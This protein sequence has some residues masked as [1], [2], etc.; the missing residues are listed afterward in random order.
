[1]PCTRTGSAERIPT[2]CQPRTTARLNCLLFA[3]LAESSYHSVGCPSLAGQ[4]SECNHESLGPDGGRSATHRRAVHCPHAAHHPPP[5]LRACRATASPPRGPLSRP[6]GA[7][8]LFH[9]AG[10]RA[11][12]A[13]APAR[14]PA[15]PVPGPLHRPVRDAALVVAAAGRSPAADDHRTPRAPRLAPAA[16]SHTTSPHPL[17]AAARAAPLAAPSAPAVRRRSC[18]GGTAHPGA[19]RGHNDPAG[20]GR[21]RAAPAPGWHTPRRRTTSAPAA[22]RPAAAAGSNRALPVPCAAAQRPGPRCSPWQRRRPRTRRAALSDSLSRTATRR[23]SGVLRRARRAP[24]P[25]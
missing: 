3:I 12:G 13:P 14:L 18:A 2:P 20:C 15:W 24:M 22:P 7:G 21:A 23:P 4:W 5:H 10:R 6:H 17:P 11:G 16:P 8:H 9:A 19:A 1:M 25:R